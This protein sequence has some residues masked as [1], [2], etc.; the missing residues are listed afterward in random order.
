MSEYSVQA[1]DH[2]QSPRNVGEIDNPDGLGEVFSMACG[3]ALKL[4]FSIDKDERIIDAR[5]K[6]AGCVSSI[7]CASAITE[8]I[9]GLTID[10]AMGITDQHI[11]DYLGG[12]PPG[13]THAPAMSREALEKAIEYF[14]SSRL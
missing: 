8:M 12:L 3:D 7:A 2:F 5:H 6:V 14:R 11:A 4:T 10:E 9:K 1:K 13:K